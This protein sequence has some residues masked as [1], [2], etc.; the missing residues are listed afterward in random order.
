MPLV[1]LALPPGVF[2]NGTEYQAQ[3]RWHDASLVRWTDGTMQPVG[4]WE[5][6]AELGGQKSRGALAWRALNGNRWLVSGTY[7]KLVVASAT[8]TI[9]D[10]TPASLVLGIDDAAVNTGYGGYFYGLGFY[11]TPRPD[12]GAYSEITTWSLDNWGEYLV[13]CSSADGRLL[14]WQ[15]NVANDAAAIS[16]APTNNLGLVVTEER[17]LVA[18][19]AGGNPRKVQWSD[20]ENNTVW[21]AAATN[22]AGDIELQTSGQIMQGIRTRGQTLILTDQDAHSMTYLGPPFVYGFERVGSGC[23]A[24]SRRSAVSVDEGVFWIGQSRIHAFS[25]GAVQE[26]PC[27]VLDY[28]FS[29]INQAQRSKVWGVANAQ[30]GEIWWFYPSSGSTE[31]DRYIAFSV[32]ERHWSIGSLSRTA[33]V[34]AGVFPNPIWFGGAGIAYNHEKGLNYGG[35][36]IF[37]ESGPVQ[38]GQGDQVLSAVELIPDEKTRGDVTLTFSTRFH[39]ND[40]ERSYGPY[41]MANPTAVRFTGRQATMRVTGARLADWRFG[42][43]RLDVRSGGRR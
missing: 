1:P 10:I 39:P 16:G 30:N 26:V 27:D 36:T 5:Q 40:T 22:Q 18:L 6:R 9:T 32:R 15:L 35:A 19:G 11:G 43:P 28:L 34:D 17:F 3:G 29:D 38:I 31:C 20:R 14:E 25:G 12:T 4:G 37:A 33:G 8:G 21:T 13:A 42:V 41:S 24:I 2:R 7:Q 23:G